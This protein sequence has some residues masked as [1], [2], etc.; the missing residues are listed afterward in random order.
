MQ[1]D[2]KVYAL[3][4]LLNYLLGEIIK[5]F[6]LIISIF[7]CLFSKVMWRLRDHEVMSACSACSEC[8]A[9]LHSQGDSDY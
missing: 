8:F 2:L 9:A 7:Q 6:Y 1:S 4:Q 5:F 3:R